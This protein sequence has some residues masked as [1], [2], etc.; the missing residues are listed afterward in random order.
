MRELSSLIGLQVIS[1]SEGKKLGSIADA[2]V[3]L[4]AGELVCVTLSKTPELRV[5]LA[6]DIDVIG[7]D[8]IM[9]ADH[10][11]VRGREDVE[12][13][14]ERGKRVL[15]NPP[16]VITSQGKTMGELGAIQIDEGS[17]KIIRF[18]VTG[19]PLKDVTEGV[20]A[21]PILDGIVHGQDTLIVPHDVVAR[22]LVQSG[23]LRGALRNLG[24]RLKVSVED[25][26]E[27]SGEFVRESEEKLKA[28]AQEA[29]KKAED[30]TEKAKE[31]VSEAAEEAKEAIER[32]GAEEGQE[33]EATESEAPEAPEPEPDAPRYEDPES[34]HEDEVVAETVPEETGLVEDTTEGPALPE[35]EEET[36]VAEEIAPEEAAEEEP[37]EDEGDEETDQDEA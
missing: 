22:R 12:K 11:R 10:D 13:E 7:D 6:E 5:I 34:E 9:V 26:S 19:G 24:E 28:R 23:G 1:T 35:A 30:A 2:Y 20:L 27:R 31:R 17:K 25:I 3:D 15:S 16:T 8:A 36:E 37:S 29:R 14:L 33:A 32:E 18:E 4:A 21:L